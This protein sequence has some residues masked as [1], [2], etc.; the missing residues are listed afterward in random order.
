MRDFIIILLTLTSLLDAQKKYVSWQKILPEASTNPQ[1]ISGSSVNN[2][3]FYD[4]KG[5]IFHKYG[6]KI[7]KFSFPGKLNLSNIIVKKISNNNFILTGFDV[8]WNAHIFYLKKGQWKK[9]RLVIKNK[10]I[11]SIIVVSPGLIYLSGN[12]GAFYRFKKNKWEKIVTP[13]KN[14]S[15]AQK[16][17][18]GI[19]WIGVRSEGIFSYDGKHFR[20]YPV[21]EENKQ[22]FFP[23]VIDDSL[24]GFTTHY[25]FF[26]P[27]SG[28]SG[29][30]P[31][32]KQPDISSFLPY[33]FGILRLNPIYSGG[34]KTFLIPKT[35]LPQSFFRLKN[36]TILL[37][38]RNGDIYFSRFIKNNF[39]DDL[40]SVYRIKGNEIAPTIQSAFLFFNDDVYPE[41]FLSRFQDK[42]FSSI[43][44]NLPGSPFYDITERTGLIFKLSPSSNIAFGD[45]NGDLKIDLV[46]ST[47]KKVNKLNIYLQNDHNEF[48]LSQTI[49]IPHQFNNRSI[50]NLSLLDFDSNGY[51]DIALTNYY[52]YGIKSGAEI[53]A[54]NSRFFGIEK[55]DTSLAHFTRGWNL[56]LISADFNNDGLNDLLVVSQW[57]NLK[58][59]LRKKKAPNEFIIKKLSNR[60]NE[61]FLGAVV[62]DYDNDGDLDI[63]ASSDLQTVYL[64]KNDGEGDFNDVANES[65][66]KKINE[67]HYSFSVRRF[68][69]F[70]DFN[71]DGRKDLFFSLGCPTNPG[72]HL[73]MQDS[74]GFFKDKAKQFRIDHPFVSAASVGDVDA[75]GDL[76]L[77]AFNKKK[78]LL[79]INNLNDSNFIEVI[80]RGVESN[81]EGLGA[82]IYLYES[83]HLNQKK[84]LKAYSQLV[85]DNFPGGAKRELAAHFGVNPHSLYD[86][87]VEF[88][89][90]ETR[91]F[92]KIKPGTI[93]IARELEGTKA[94]LFLLPGN[95]IRFALETQNQIYGLIFLLVFLMLTLGTKFGIRKF[96]WTSFTSILIIFVNL[97][98]FWIM[99]LANVESGG[100][101]LKYLLPAIFP[102][103]GI[104]IS[105]F[106]SYSL[107]K[108]IKF[109]RNPEKLKEELLKKVTAFT[110]GQWAQKN[111][112]A[113]NLLL[114]NPPQEAE[115][116]KR[117]FSLLS[118][119]RETFLKLTAPLISE[120]IGLLEELDAEKEN[121]EML[122]TQ[123]DYLK[124][125]LPLLKEDSL[126]N[127]DK[128]KN[129]GLQIDLLRKLLSEI[130][131]TI[132][133]HFSCD[134]E[135]IV[136]K[137]AFE[138][139]NELNNKNISL[140]KKKNYANKIAVLIKN[141]ELGFVLDNCIQNSIR[142]LEERKGAEINVLIKKKSP[143]VIIEVIDNGKGI[144]KNMFEKIF[145]EGVSLSGSGGNG[146]AI[147]R[148][149]L[150]KYGG[151][152][153]VSASIPNE[154]TILTIELMQVK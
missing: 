138:Y 59:L 143:K 115:K 54:M 133:E 38:T 112:N 40:A 6:N 42:D 33:R 77:L 110:H 63:F 103:T 67:I 32:L 49:E 72:N 90:G 107:S 122:I 31:S 69:T 147:A 141:Y 97:S 23:V 153:Y 9:D 98:L 3:W 152:I 47:F 10:P 144:E 58:L 53:L 43:L 125:E 118:R 12:W 102:L 93:F 74:V 84:Y 13:F 105:F 2:F 92:R 5:N 73:F 137:V 1:I 135:E 37:T 111:I 117:F 101:F 145:E 139:E 148:E 68:M 51:P 27:D 129:V 83:G 19:I 64:F 106:V 126:I 71:N 70:G 116:T 95:I 109:K 34:E 36:G 75:D 85:C 14:H 29:F 149:T 114:S 15:V 76:D 20:H 17:R 46:T 30:K 62:F 151:R 8:N 41:V 18:H 142:A 123:I 22:D 100:F 80:P 7:L 99:I 66:F 55:I 65:G 39:F 87:K 24:L 128:I 79:W 4:N 154:Q 136:K 130:R 121:R 48:Q 104:L 52:G 113:M 81:R 25:D 119:R 108:S 82:K 150:K 44:L 131:L 57:R 16:D 91:T 120:I 132:F 89:G 134:P 26:V 94:F 78:N 140:N 146:L 124:R 35:F 61:A 50:K 11:S 56:Q 28:F 86:V 21:G 45:L 88:Y 127:K 96:K 60:K